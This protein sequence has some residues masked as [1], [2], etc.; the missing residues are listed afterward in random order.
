MSAPRRSSAELAS[1][2]K[3]AVTRIALA[4]LQIKGPLGVGRPFFQGPATRSATRATRSGQGSFMAARAIVCG[5]A[6]MAL[7]AWARRHPPQAL[8]FLRWLL[9]AAATGASQRA[10]LNVRTK[11]NQGAAVDAPNRRLRCAC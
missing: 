1:G 2:L 8:T 6:L 5:V 4:A 11:I 9:A 10:T 3:R 7:A